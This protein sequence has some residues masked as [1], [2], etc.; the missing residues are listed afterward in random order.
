M[1]KCRTL[2][3]ENE[4]FGKLASS[5]RIA[6]L[7]NDLALQKNFSEDMKKSQLGNFCNNFIAFKEQ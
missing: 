6:K 5:G 1:Q 3:E 2:L 4:E 7:E